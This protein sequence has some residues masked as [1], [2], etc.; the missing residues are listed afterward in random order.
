M[1]FSRNHS[2]ILI[3]KQNVRKSGIFNPTFLTNFLHFL[4][5]YEQNE[6]QDMHMY[7]RKI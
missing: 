5:A 2:V 1:L 3:V 7:I 4:M 6:L